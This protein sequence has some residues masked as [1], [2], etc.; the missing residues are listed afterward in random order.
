MKN[1]FS[2]RGGEH[3]GSFRILL[4][5]C[6][7]L[8]ITALNF[9]GRTGA[10]DLASLD[11]LAVIKIASRIL[12]IALLSIVLVTVRNYEQSKK[13]FRQLIPFGIFV[14]WAIASTLW[15]P[16]PSVSLGHGVDLLI[17]LMISALCGISCN[18]NQ[19]ISR[20]FKHL[21]FIIFL[22]LLISLF[23][24]Y[25]FPSEGIGELTNRPS[26]IGHPNDI[27]ASA[28]IGLV[29]VIFCSKYWS[30]TWARRLLIPAVIVNV[31]FMFVARS[32]LALIVSFIVLCVTFI[33][34]FNKKTVALVI[35]LSSLTITTLIC[36]GTIDDIY[37][38]M[39]HYL[40][41]GQGEQEF[42]SGSGR[43]EIWKGGLNS[44]NESPLIG[45]GYYAFSPTGLVEV[46]KSERPF[47]AH[48]IILHV[49]TGTGIIG[50]L[51]FIYGLYPMASKLIHSLVYPATINEKNLSV[52]SIMLVLWFMLF[53][54]AE[55]SILGAVRPSFIIFYI[56][57]GISTRLQYITESNI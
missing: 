31:Y 9:P 45:N 22:I 11:G 56:V 18:S 39:T 3:I 26:A 55:I 47:G 46:G 19:R 36:T 20:V 5:V 28:G 53:G 27:A 23:L 43:V 15:S 6:W 33:L 40:M 10:P 29:L 17:L 54:F 16:I 38:K 14:M 32:R 8:S 41:R 1:H 48:N 51:L 50:L 49:L 4:L 44:L 57:M 13:V 34:T 12:S 30:W 25:R 42:W 7:I 35:T 24:F 21:F 37:Y 2:V 52:M